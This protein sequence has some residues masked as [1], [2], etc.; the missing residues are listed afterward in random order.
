MNHTIS[1]K[2]DEVMSARAI[3]TILIQVTFFAFFA[4]NR[5]M[6][7]T[8]KCMYFWCLTGFDL[9]VVGLVL[10]AKKKQIWIWKQKCTASVKFTLDQTIY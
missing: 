6:T 8:L 4:Q 2:T 1:I 5:D 3:K 7:I 10:G 9:T